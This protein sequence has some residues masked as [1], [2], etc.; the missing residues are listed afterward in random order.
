MLL[1]AASVVVPVTARTTF[2]VISPFAV[3]LRF[4]PT[5][6]SVEALI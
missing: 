2:C 4:P 6:P 1:P 5:A 3:T